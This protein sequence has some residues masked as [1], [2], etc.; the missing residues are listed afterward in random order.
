MVHHRM[1]KGSLG[2]SS[3]ARVDGIK[4]ERALAARRAEAG[5]SRC[6]ASAER[7]PAQARHGSNCARAYAHALAFYESCAVRKARGGGRIG[8][9]EGEHLATK[10]AGCHAVFR[11]SK[12]VPAL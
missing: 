7:L 6:F 4:L 11:A 2:V 10:A 12:V 1:K 8:V 3:L 9:L 5:G